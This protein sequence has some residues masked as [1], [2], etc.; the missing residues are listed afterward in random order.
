MLKKITLIGLTCLLASSV[1]AQNPSIIPVPS[2]AVYPKGSYPLA[3]SIIIAGPK[4][5]AL[6]TTYANLS[7]KLSRIAGKKVQWLYDQGSAA[8]LASIRFKLNAKA[9]AALGNEGYQL[10]SDAKGVQITANKPVGLFYGIQTLLQLMP[11]EIESTKAVAG[12]K[13]AIPYANITDTPRFAWRGIMLDVARHFFTKEEVKRFIDEM[14]AYKYNVLHFHLTDDEGWRVEIKS[15]PNLTKKGAFNVKKVG[16]FTDFS[17]PLPDEP[18]TYGG[19]Y[20]QDDIKELVKYGQERFVNIMPE[21]DVPGHS[22]AAVASYPELSCT[23]EAVNYQVIS[24]EPFIDWSHGHPEALQDNTLC[25][26]NEKVYTF[27]DSVMGEVSQLFPFEYIHMGGDECPKNYWDKNPQILAMRKELGLK[28]SQEV[29]AHFVRKLEKIITSKGKRMMGWDEILEGGGLPKNTA[30]MSWRGMEGGIQAAKDG[31]EVVM[32]P[33]NHVYIDLMQGDKAIEPPVY[34]TVRLRDSYAFNPVPEGVDAKLVKGG[35]ANL[36]SE[37]L[38]NYRHLQYMTYP[39]SFAIA[40]ALWSE[41]ANRNWDNFVG[42]VEAHMARFDVAQKKYAP[43]MFEPII[44]VKRN[45]V[46]ELMVQLST[47]I[48]GLTIHYS[49][50]HSFPDQF[51]PMA[52]GPVLVPKDATVMKIVTYRGDKAMGRT[53]DLTVTDMIKRA[54]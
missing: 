11:K 54:K 46:G 36:W 25:P 6:S 47:E 28:N 30:V 3:S 4:D 21:I 45:E 7:D 52:T 34:K 20:T 12:V 16:H 38:F 8:S 39:R 26:A 14:V 51:Y 22:M 33:N 50:D 19:F 40:E 18:R 13:W 23:P 41:P 5:A 44:E 17:R 37:Q 53:I 35:Q 42:R 10:T 2:K 1:F 32:T 27:L 43:S 29:Q 15:F 24:G 48:S 9:D 49:F 31:H